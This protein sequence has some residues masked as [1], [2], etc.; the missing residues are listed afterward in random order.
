M[1]NCQQTSIFCSKA[2]M[3]KQVSHGKKQRG[4][5]KCRYSRRGMTTISFHFLYQLA[6]WIYILHFN[7]P[8]NKPYTKLS[9]VH[10]RCH[11]QRLIGD[12]AI[13]V[14][15]RYWIM[16]LLKTSMH[17]VMASWHTLLQ[18]WG[19]GLKTRGMSCHV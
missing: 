4:M 10:E 1:M 8:G 13:T 14:L 18:T 5:G 19:W 17:E 12:S 2:T 16:C 15:K 3:A 6:L 11:E 7:I 9:L